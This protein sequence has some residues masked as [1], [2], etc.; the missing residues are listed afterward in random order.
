MELNEIQ[1]RFFKGEGQWIYLPSRVELWVSD[2]GQNYKKWTETARI[3]TDEK[4]A[5]TTFVNLKMKTRFVKF[6]IRN[7]GKIPAGRQG[8]GH[9][10]WLFVDE[11]RVR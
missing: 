3:K 8:A 6:S 1:F 4:V 5:V 11:I 9:G 7:F 2:D 10:A